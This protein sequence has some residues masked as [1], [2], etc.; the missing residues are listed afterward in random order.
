M[1]IGAVALIVFIAGSCGFNIPRVWQF[2]KENH[3]A[4]PYIVPILPD[5]LDIRVHAQARGY[6]AYV[7]GKLCKLAYSASISGGWCDRYIPDNRGNPYINQD[8]MTP[9]QERVFGRVEL[10]PIERTVLT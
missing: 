7:D 10:R 5:P 2:L 4:S 9:A 8:S 1:T 6:R 3:A